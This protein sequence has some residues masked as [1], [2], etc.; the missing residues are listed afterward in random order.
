MLRP[1]QDWE[2]IRHGTPLKNLAMPVLPPILRANHW[3]LVG[4]LK[5]GIEAVVLAVSL[6][7][8]VVLNILVV[9]QRVVTT[10]PG[11]ATDG[12]YIRSG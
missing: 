8:H 10:F 12:G 9:V 11:V 6:V 7:N 5:R 3:G 2:V 4:I 1:W